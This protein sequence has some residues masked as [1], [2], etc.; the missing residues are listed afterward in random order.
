MQRLAEAYPH[1]KGIPIESYSNVQP[2]ILIGID[3]ANI[4]LPLKG[5][6]GK[7]HEPIATKTPLCWIVHGGGHTHGDLVGYHAVCAYAESSDQ[8]LQK[9]VREYFSLE[10]LGI[11]ESRK[12]LISSED[13]RAEKILQSIIQ[14]DSG[15]YEVKLL[16]KFDKI[17]LPNSKPVALRRFHCLEN[18]MKRQPELAAVLHAKL[19]DYQQKRYIRK[20]SVDELQEAH[21]RVWYLPLFPVFNLNEPGKVRIVWDAAAKTIGVSLISMILKG[22]DLLTPLDSVLYR[23]REFRVGLSGDI[24]EMYLQMVMSKQDQHCLRVLWCDDETNKP[25]T[26]VTQVM[27]FATSC[28]PSCAQYVKNLNAVKF[29]GQYPLAVQAIVKQHYVD[30]ML[31][32]VESEEVAIQVAKDVKYIHAQAG[33]DMRNWISNSRAV[34][35]A[36]KEPETDKKNLNLGSELGTE[37]VLGMWWCTET[38]TITYKLYAKHDTDLL[39]QLRKPTK[40]EVF[41]TLM[42]VFDPLGLISNVLVYLKVL[43]QEIWRSGIEWDQDIPE[44]LNAK[45]KK[46]A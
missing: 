24:R 4:T 7:M 31:V 17:R 20:L 16:W 21:D 44:S 25:S 33:F 41:R 14:T 32:S 46:K 22:P 43:F 5:K 23:F 11:C 40:K 37:K 15:R 19:R 34:V 18:K 13:Q 9:A 2:R 8:M 36:M 42:A 12:P 27:P 10:S 35:E 39:S 45:W 30:D 26:Y 28:S 1:L 3:N 6:E 38:D 29:E